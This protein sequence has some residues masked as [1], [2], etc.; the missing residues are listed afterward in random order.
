MQSSIPIQSLK[1]HPVLALMPEMRGDQWARFL[2][3]IR[4][5]GVTEPVS[6][7][8]CLILDL[9]GRERWKAA[10]ECGLAT[11]PVKQMDLSAL[12]QMFFVL[13]SASIRQHFNDDQRAIVGARIRK[14]LSQQLKIERARKAG[15]SGGRGNKRS[16]KTCGP[17][18]ATSFSSREIVAREMGVSRKLIERAVEL[19]EN[20]T[21]LADKI[22]LGRLTLKVACREMRGRRLRRELLQSSAP[23]ITGSYRLVHGDSFKLEI[24]PESIDV[25]ITDPPYGRGIVELCEKLA[26]L[27]ER[28][29]RPGGSLLA[30]TGQLWF[31]EILAAM[32]KHLHYHWII[33]YEMPGG[34]AR[35]MFPLKVNP[36][37]KPVVW[38]SKGQPA[39]DR[40]VND[41]CRSNRQDKSLHDWQQSERG[42][43]ELVEQYSEQGQLVLD[44]FCGTATTGVACLRLGRRFLGID[45]NEEAIRMSAGRL[46]KVTLGEN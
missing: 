33:S 35:P 1:V 13:Q 5:H 24:E 20:A 38:F 23:R 46:A 8:D 27:G 25:I 6:V 40:I 41:V 3:H 15:A 14:P 42:I 34:S 7:Q 22:L 12:D 30:I 2:D 43:F 32:T 10:R 31:P 9:D 11:I 26:V 18:G 44:P 45:D 28:V 21:D 37:W 16:A 39:I 17:R 19:D 36:H 4:N 29:L